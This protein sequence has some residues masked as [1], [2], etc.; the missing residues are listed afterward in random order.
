[1]IGEQ[2][3]GVRAG[4]AEGDFGNIAGEIFECEETKCNSQKGQGQ[5]SK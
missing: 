1:M 2:A 3:A 4:E 5:Q